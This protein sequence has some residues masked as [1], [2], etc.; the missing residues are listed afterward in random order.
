M[1]HKTSTYQRWMKTEDLD[2][3]INEA[4]KLNHASDMRPEILC[5][6]YSV[7]IKKAVVANPI[8]LKCLVSVLPNYQAAEKRTSDWDFKQFRSEFSQA[9]NAA[10]SYA[11]LNRNYEAFDKLFELR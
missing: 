3:L 2:D 4:E 7:I 5:A 11:L 1:R 6:L 9:H 8:A 10:I